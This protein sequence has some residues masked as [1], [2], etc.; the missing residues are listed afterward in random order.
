[1]S[2]VDVKELLEAGV[3]FGH[4]TRRWNPKMKSFIFEARNGIHIINLSHTAEQ[5]TKAQ[6]FL[7]SISQGGGD[8]LFVGTK[9]QAKEV[10]KQAALRSSSAYVIER[11]LGGMMTNLKTIRRSINR[12]NELDAMDADGRTALMNKKEQSMHR[13]ESEKLHRNLDGIRHMDGAPGAMVI[14]DV[15]Y[16]QIALLEAKKLNI[17]VVAIVDTNVNPIGVDYPIAGNDDAIRSIKIIV[18]ALAAAVEE[19]RKNAPKKRPKTATTKKSDGTV[20]SVKIT[21]ADEIEAVSA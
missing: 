9:K 15:N 1:M 5:I 20:E 6:D 3:H 2:N 13:H 10:V 12:L 14:V 18:D 8:I 16:E 4:Q 21:E 7:R 19:G 17:P 11:W